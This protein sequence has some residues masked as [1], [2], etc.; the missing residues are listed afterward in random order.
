LGARSSQDS[1]TIRASRN[2]ILSVA[3]GQAESLGS[4]IFASWCAD[5]K[6][7]LELQLCSF[8]DAGMFPILSLEPYEVGKLSI[9]LAAGHDRPAGQRLLVVH[10]RSTTGGERESHRA[11]YMDHGFDEEEVVVMIKEV[12]QSLHNKGMPP[13]F[14]ATLGGE[15]DFSDS[16]MTEV[17]TFYEQRDDL[18][19]ISKQ[20]GRL[21]QQGILLVMGPQ[22]SGSSELKIVTVNGWIDRIMGMTLPPDAEASDE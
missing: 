9:I 15:K 20:P 5:D 12:I 19:E 2:N 17:Q 16:D 7:A 1:D 6:Y 11:A 3:I 21:L 13:F 4:L 18:I 22:Q 8:R 14:I 10:G